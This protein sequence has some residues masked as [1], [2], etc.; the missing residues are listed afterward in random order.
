MLLLASD[1]LPTNS[2]QS[3]NLCSTL[4]QIPTQHQQTAQDE[5][6]HKRKAYNILF[7]FFESFFRL[8]F[9]LFFST[10]IRFDLKFILRVC[11]CCVGICLNVLQRFKLCTEFVGNSSLASSSI[12]STLACSHNT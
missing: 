11:W 12:R 7:L 9:C 3:L 4:R 6:G 5:A 2:V 10:F 1:E 8:L